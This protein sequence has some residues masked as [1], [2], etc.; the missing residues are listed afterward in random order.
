MNQ[1]VGSICVLSVA[2][3]NSTKRK[4]VAYQDLCIFFSGA[5]HKYWL[6]SYN[7]VGIMADTGRGSQHISQIFFK[8]SRSTT[9][10]PFSQFHTT[11]LNFTMTST[12]ITPINYILKC[13]ILVTC[14]NVCVCVCEITIPTLFKVFVYYL[15]F[16]IPYSPSS[17]NDTFPPGQ[18]FHWL[19]FLPSHYA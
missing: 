12:I 9:Y 3:A 6:K 2:I 15:L 18:Q 8:I 4:C 5:F 17:Y 13:H 19:I 11:W 16:K 14:S 10:R 1:M 7:V